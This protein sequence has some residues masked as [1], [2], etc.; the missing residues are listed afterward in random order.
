MPWGAIRGGA[1]TGMPEEGY[2]QG[3]GV[4]YCQSALCPLTRRSKA[5]KFILTDED[6]EEYLKREDYISNTRV[7]PDDMDFFGWLSSKDADMSKT[8]EGR[9]LI[10]ELQ[11]VD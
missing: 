11:A 9:K 5:V 10:A 3:K 8:R 7:R 6:Y 4:N 2:L 1:L